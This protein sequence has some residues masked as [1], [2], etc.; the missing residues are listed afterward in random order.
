[1]SLEQVKKGLGVLAVVAGIVSAA[2]CGSSYSSAPTAPN[3]SPS[4]TPGAAADVTITING[5]LGAQSYSPNPATVKVGQTVSWKNADAIAHTATGAGF[6]TGAI[7]PG[8]TSA[9]IAFSAAG[10]IAY[11]CSFHPTMTGTLNVQ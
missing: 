6:D 10:S 5:M 7:N 3:P 11:H 2:A 8:Q 9:P 1:M 4:G